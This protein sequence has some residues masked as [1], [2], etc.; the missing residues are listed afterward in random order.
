MPPRGLYSAAHDRNNKP[1]KSV[2]QS[3]AQRKSR[4]CDHDKPYPGAIFAPGAAPPN[5]AS[6]TPEQRQALRISQLR[7]EGR[8]IDQDLADV[9]NLG[10]PVVFGDD[11]EF[12][13]EVHTGP[14]IRGPQPGRKPHA[15]RDEDLLRDTDYDPD[16]RISA[17]Q[18]SP[19]TELEPLD[20]LN[21]DSPVLRTLDDNLQKLFN[22]AKTILSAAQQVKNAAA[23]NR[24]L[25]FHA[26]ELASI[27]DNA[28]GNWIREM[29][30]H[31]DGILK[32]VT[33]QAGGT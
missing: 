10:R 7:R 20:G 22:T 28:V 12:A 27:A 1:G 29:D 17:L 9:E 11:S 14:H 26:E 32:V 21:P 5:A 18:E 4:S 31:L 3:R 24:E 30:E 6:P 19:E 16:M 13:G 23:G 15:L 8:V 2:K 25:E 33:N